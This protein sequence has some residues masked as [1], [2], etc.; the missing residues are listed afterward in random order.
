MQRFILDRGF[1]IYGDRSSSDRMV[2]IRYCTYYRLPV[3]V[4]VRTAIVTIGSV[5]WCTVLST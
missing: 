4:V 2:R 1:M 5:L 3:A